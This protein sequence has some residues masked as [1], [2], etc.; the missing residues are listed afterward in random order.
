MHTWNGGD[1]A[2][3][4]RGCLSSRRMAAARSDRTWRERRRGW[5][6][7]RRRPPDAEQRKQR[8][9]TKADQLSDSSASAET[10]EGSEASRKRARVPAGAR[11]RRST[12][13]RSKPHG[14]RE[15][16]GWKPELHWPEKLDGMRALGTGKE[17]DGVA[18]AYSDGARLVQGGSAARNHRNGDRWRPVQGA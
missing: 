7:R 4:E 12:G 15:V 6:A 18:Q 8:T 13:P 2:H 1:F 5:R 10:V 17:T 11:R 14:T 9:K 3:S 16:L